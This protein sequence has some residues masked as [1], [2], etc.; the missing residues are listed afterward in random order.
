M[1]VLLI[2]GCD[3]YTVDSCAKDPRAARVPWDKLSVR[4]VIGISLFLIAGKGAHVGMYRI[5]F[6]RMTVLR[7]PSVEHRLSRIVSR[8]SLGRGRARQGEHHVRAKSVSVRRL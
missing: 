4:I 3:S 1:G 8:G 5:A 6:R 7:A 2:V